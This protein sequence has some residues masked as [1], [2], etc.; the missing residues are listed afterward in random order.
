M[1]VQ[2]LQMI[3][4]LNFNE[5]MLYT[6]PTISLKFKE[7]AFH[8]CTLPLSFLLVSYPPPSIPTQFGARMCLNVVESK[9]GHFEIRSICNDVN[10]FSTQISY[11]SIKSNHNI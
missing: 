3:V 2:L 11:N 7:E 9:S 10:H 6:L 1:Q 8:W 4:D 5:F